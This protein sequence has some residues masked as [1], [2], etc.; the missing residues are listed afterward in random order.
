MLPNC[1][2]CTLKA[3]RSLRITQSNGS[4]CDG[5]L[6]FFGTEVIIY[7]FELAWWDCELTLRS[8]DCSE[9][10]M[11]RWVHRCGHSRSGG[12]RQV[13]NNLK[14]ACSR[15]L[16]EYFATIDLNGTALTVLLVLIQQKKCLICLKAVRCLGTAS[17]LGPRN[18]V[19]I[20]VCY[21]SSKIAQ[22][23]QFSQGWWTNKGR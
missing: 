1:R 12:W 17:L 15:T 18:Y 4:R 16:V 5:K 7:D 21:S 2:Y 11:D 9:T 8:V 6:F 14:M 19:S 22:V 3:K 13:C 10:F 20:S 23:K